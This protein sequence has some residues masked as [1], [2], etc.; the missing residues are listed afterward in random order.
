MQKGDKDT[1]DSS[2]KIGMDKHVPEVAYARGHNLK[3]CFLCEDVFE[4]VKYTNH[5]L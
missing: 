3:Q 5:I 2:T 4:C 1:E